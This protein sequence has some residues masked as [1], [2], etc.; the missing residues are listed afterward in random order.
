MLVN[1]GDDREELRQMLAGENPW[2]AKRAPRMTEAAK[3][4]ALLHD[5]QLSDE[6]REKLKSQ[7][8]AIHNDETLTDEE[9]KQKI[10]E[11]IEVQC[12][13]VESLYA[14]AGFEAE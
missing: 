2:H 5:D 8:E 9:K 6:H 1:A 12:R 7:M 10:K 3:M 13:V 4:A 11:L 14:H